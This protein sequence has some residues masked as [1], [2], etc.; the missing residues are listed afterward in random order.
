[1]EHNIVAHLYPCSQNFQMVVAAMQANPR[2]SFD[3]LN[4]PIIQDLSSLVGTQVTYDGDGKG[5]RRDFRWI[6]GGDD[7]P[8]KASSIIIT[9]PDTVSLQIVVQPQ[10]I[11]SPAYVN[12]VRRFKQG[13]ATTDA[14]LNELGLS[15]PPTRGTQT[16]ASGEIYL[17]RK[18]GRGTFGVVRCFWNVSTGEERAV[19]TPHRSAIENGQVD[20]AAWAREARIM[21]LISHPHI[22]KLIES[23]FHPQPEL[24]LEYMP[25]G[26]LQHWI[27]HRKGISYPETV[28]ITHQC[29]SALA[30]LHGQATP[31]AHRDIKPTNI[32]IQTR[33]RGA[34]IFVKL[35]DF[36]TA[37]PDLDLSTYCGTHLYLAPEVH[38]D[39]QRR[40]RLERTLGHA[41]TVD[42]W[43]LGV[44]AYQLLYSLRG[45][46]GLG[47]ALCESIE[48]ELRENVRRTPVALGSILVRCMVVMSPAARWS[49]SQCCNMLEEMLRTERGFFQGLTSAS[50]SA[51][52]DQ[53]TLTPKPPSSALTIN[54]YDVS[55]APR[56][57]NLQHEGYE[58]DAVFKDHS[59]SGLNRY[60]YG[61]SIAEEFGGNDSEDWA[62]DFC[63]ESLQSQTE[64]QGS[65]Q[66]QIEVAGSQARTRTSIPRGESEGWRLQGGNAIDA[67]D[68]EEKKEAA[69]L[70]E[71]IGGSYRLREMNS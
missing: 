26:S 31:I 9:I 41:T 42:I 46:T 13:A 7:H 28:T 18:I 43:S 19:K 53:A 60:H 15:N 66:S 48:R 21:S 25:Y 36:G 24:H 10:N 62:S 23:F 37:R 55:Q 14:L 6:V 29:L 34:I 70:R 38:L 59:A 63:Q 69:L 57:N 61:S 12:G 8:R 40:V 5:V 68:D 17:K 33:S 2:L 20:H 35:S 11:E 39:E 3:D 1:M 32:L 16:P 45:C 27:K 71:A 44:V 30:Y 52:E 22:V 65:S 58:L 67:D 49:A 50:S 64:V 54:Q 47:V 56:Y 51:G 4:R